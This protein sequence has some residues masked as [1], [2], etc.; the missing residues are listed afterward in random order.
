MP[1]RTPIKLATDRCRRGQQSERGRPGRTL[2]V[3]DRAEPYVVRFH[4]HVPV[5]YYLLSRAK[6]AGPV[7]TVRTVTG[8][9][10]TS[11]AGDDSGPSGATNGATF[12]GLR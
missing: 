3:R 12:C 1:L 5:Q 2:C 9:R 8:R 6:N 10:L 4:R 7:L 11:L